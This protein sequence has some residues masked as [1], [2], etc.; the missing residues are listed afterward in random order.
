MQTRPRDARS[1][2]QHEHELIPSWATRRRGLYTQALNGGLK[3]VRSYIYMFIHILAQ[4]KREVRKISVFPQCRCLWEHLLRLLQDNVWEHYNAAKGRE[5]MSS[6]PTRARR[7]DFLKG[8]ARDPSVSKT[9]K[10]T[11]QPTNPQLKRGTSHQSLTDRLRSSIT[12]QAWMW[13]D[14][15]NAKQ[16]W[17]WKKVF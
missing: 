10:P 1:S 12:D 13:F 8:T 6:R 7:N 4:R 3:T 11:N 2:Q 17:N 14:I 5:R 9:N 15:S 16:E